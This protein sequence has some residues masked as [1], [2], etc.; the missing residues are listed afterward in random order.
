MVLPLAH[1][2][3]ILEAEPI[4]LMLLE[5]LQL[6]VS[7][8]TLAEWRYIFPAHFSLNYETETFKFG[9]FSS[10]TQPFPFTAFQSRNMKLQKIVQVMPV[11]EVI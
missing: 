2:E 10:D 9:G 4:F 7:S 1:L 3:L 6:Y 8:I 11:L 5:N